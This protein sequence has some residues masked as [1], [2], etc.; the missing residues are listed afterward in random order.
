VINKYTIQ[1]GN[2]VAVAGAKLQILDENGNVV[3][4]ADGTRCEWTTSTTSA[5]KD[6]YGLPAHEIVGLP[7]GSYTLHE[8][9]APTGY[10]TAADVVFTVNS[11]NTMA[12]LIGGQQPQY[13]Y[14]YM[15]DDPTL[16]QFSKVDAESGVHIVGAK[17]QV[18][19]LNGDVIK[20]WTTDGSVHTITHLPVGNY[21][22]VEIEA[23][24][25]YQKADDVTFVVTDSSNAVNVIMRDSR[26]YG[27]LELNKTDAQ[28]GNSLKDVVFNIISVNNVVDPVTN[29]VIYT[30][31]QVVDILTTD[32]D[33]HAK[34]ENHIPIGT[35]GKNGE[36]VAIQYQLIEVETVTGSQ[37][38][39][40]DAIELEFTYI[41]DMTPIVEISLDL[42][43]SK[44]QIHVTKSGTPE[45]FVGQYENRNNVTVIKN[46]DL[47]EYTIT[48][49][50]N[51]MASA[52][53]V[54]VRDF[55]P[56]NTDFIAI[57]TVH[58]GVYD[59]ITNAV[60]WDID[61]IKAG[62][63]IELKF[64]VK[65]NNNSACEI[66]N[67]AEYAM[68][69]EIPGSDTDRLD[70]MDDNNQWNKTEAVVHQTVELHKTSVVAGG[71]NTEDAV[72]VSPDDRIHYTIEFT[73]VDDVH[74]IVI[75]DRIPNGLIYVKDSAKINGI[76]DSKISLN[77]ET[78]ELVFSDVYANNETIR[79]EFDVIVDEIADHTTVYYLNQAMAK[80]S[81]REGNGKTEEIKSEIVS[82]Y[83]DK[84]FSVVKHGAPFTFEGNY[85]YHKNVTALQKDDVITYQ[86]TATNDGDSVV[87]NL[88]IVDKIPNGLTY[89]SHS[90]VDGI[91]VWVDEEAGL[92]T[93]CIDEI[94]V[95][96]SASVQFKA[97]IKE[98]K[99]QLIINSAVYGTVN[100][101]GD[102]APSLNAES[103]RTNDVVHQV[104]EFHKT[105]EVVG[106]ADKESATPVAVGDTLIYTL[107][108]MSIEDLTNVAIHDILPDGL[109]FVPD[110]IA[111][112]H[113]TWDKWLEIDDENGY[114]V[115]GDGNGTVFFN[116]DNVLAGD[117]FVR[118]SAT[119]DYIPVNSSAFFVNQASVRYDV[120]TG[121]SAET[122]E[123]DILVSE[124]VAHMTETK[125]EGVK[126]GAKATYVG[127]Y[128]S[129]NN[130]TIVND[131]DE[132][133]YI[134]TVKNAGASDMCNV[135]IR[136][137]IPEHTTFKSVANSGIYNETGNY[138]E[139]VIDRL[140]SGESTTVEFTVIC[141]SK[142]K[143]VEIRNIAAYAAPENPDD[144]Q[145]NEWLWTDE[146]IYQ[147]VEFHKSA[148]IGHG[149]DVT[150]AKYVAIGTKFSYI[151]TFS[152]TNTVYDLSVT[153]KI[154]L[155]LTYVPNTA[156]CQF[157][158]GDA[159]SVEV[160]VG[161]KNELAFK[162]ID[163]IPSGT[164]TLRFDVVV[165]DVAEFDIDYFFINQANAVVKSSQSS[166]DTVKLTSETVSNKTV[167]T[168]KVDPPKLGD[169]EINETLMWT[170]VA[171]IS[172]V[173]M[174]IFGYYGFVDNKK[175]R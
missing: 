134:I 146:V 161:E 52:W 39:P 29:E 35:Y 61:E 173:S 167:K 154:P 40:I 86:L 165:E 175:K 105:S 64:T 100:E 101:V 9:S 153:D 103:K 19:D 110:S 96:E 174:I 57:D 113:S 120:V 37:Y 13:T 77:P 158:N 99:A 14:V 118:F 97:C 51:G 4:L 75:T 1:D 46:G 11:T 168:N 157:S 18:V 73:S 82:H 89:L 160:T 71:S 159:N 24:H 5:T 129:R 8:V 34:T 142:G 164:V 106:G 98:Q 22:L 92:L 123:T 62:N 44:P 67:I 31:G 32:A 115:D 126:D 162:I 21:T 81:T 141:D 53:N 135:V 26:T 2:R 28:T 38:A 85:E 170:S 93:W 147:T 90:N 114:V 133:T 36:F 16:V 25:G 83:A 136:D 127:D 27:S 156:T 68:P 104:V 43:N 50:N 55:I 12:D 87:H 7:D 117:M 74:N 59:A 78:N 58:N 72:V 109:T 163:E 76:V 79:F 95:G 108:L 47:I 33:G 70:P 23:P 15:K 119:V 122:P 138:A 128:G 41:N 111:V 130:V 69:T 145:D 80:Y 150:D 94:L 151:L 107:K 30:K 6:E 63:A 66:V 84:Y 112:K 10:A 125:I 171:F 169:D 155:G 124:Q 166:D 172:A 116:E 42:K 91:K 143:A 56:E 20:E 45:T 48:V 65:A 149:T 121:D 152:T 140:K 60:Y 17:L 102:N 131:G 49:R 132:I 139:W 144:I 3:V 137:A 88:V 148:S 54:V